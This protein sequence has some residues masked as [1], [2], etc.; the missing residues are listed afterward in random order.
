MKK[1]VFGL[2]VVLLVV[3]IW[4]AFVSAIA[5]GWVHL[6]LAAAATLIALGIGMAKPAQSG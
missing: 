1:L 6:P 4:L 2:A 3:W 5:S